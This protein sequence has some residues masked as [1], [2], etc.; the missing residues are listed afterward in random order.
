MICLL[1]LSGA[2]TS[3]SPPSLQMKRLKRE[4]LLLRKLRIQRGRQEMNGVSQSPLVPFRP[5]YLVPP[6]VR[7]VD[8][9][10]SFLCGYDYYLAVLD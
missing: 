6:D 10:F 5:S 8:D 1:S 7:S 2:V 9:L 4:S 3:V